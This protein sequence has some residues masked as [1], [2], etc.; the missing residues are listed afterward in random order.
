MTLNYR[1]IV[2]KVPKL[3][4]VVSNSIVGRETDS[5]LDIKLA[6][7]Q[8]PHIFLKKRKGNDVLDI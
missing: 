8:V 6:G 2:E 7:D 1:M 3:N 5:L 4:G